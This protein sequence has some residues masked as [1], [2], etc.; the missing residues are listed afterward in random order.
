MP[1]EGRQPRVATSN[2]TQVT[3]VMGVLNVTPDSFSDGGRWL[4][5][6]AA[7]RHGLDMIAEGAD[8]VDVGGESTRPGAEPVAEEEERRRVVPVIEALAETGRVRVSVDTRKAS[9]AEAAVAAGATLINDVSASLW[10]VAA[11]TRVGW[12]AMHMQGE[13]RT[14]QADPYYTDVVGEVLEFLVRRSAEAEAAGVAEIWIDPGIG[15][16]KNLDHNLRLLRH[17]DQLVAT[18]RPVAIG[19]SRKSFLGRL[20]PTTE[21]APAPVEDRLEGSL[22]TAVWAINLGVGMVRV[23]D[24]AP[25]VQAVRLAGTTKAAE[26]VVGS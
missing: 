22:A 20:A 24:V 21:G 3:L 4:E 18:G 5:R 13:P 10:P 15:F 23:H 16:G 12:V 17:L 1:S 26:R 14:M 8:V 11:A 9:V 25:T 7:I 19:T 2:V 6:D